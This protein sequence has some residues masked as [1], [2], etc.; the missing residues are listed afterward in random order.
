MNCE[1]QDWIDSYLFNELEG[2]ERKEFEVKYAND[3]AFRME[4]DLQV[5]VFAGINDYY[6]AQ[7]KR[8]KATPQKTLAMPKFS[9]AIA[10]AI[11][12]L[13]IAQVAIMNMQ[14]NTNIRANN[15]IK[16]PVKMKK[17]NI[18]NGDDYE[19][20]QPVSP[21]YPKY[22]IFTFIDLKLG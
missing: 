13:L 6:I 5:E 9:W 8:P 15:T 10:A 7:A 16:L 17:I 2:E 3:E 14:P 18:S 11:A 1:Q 21:K 12:F 22:T 19:K 4:V 20:V